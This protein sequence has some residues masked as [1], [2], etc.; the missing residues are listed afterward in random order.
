MAE[1]KNL[2]NETSASTATNR[3]ELFHAQENLRRAFKPVKTSLARAIV[4]TK[5]CKANTSKSETLRLSVEQRV[6]FAI[7]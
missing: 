2:G 4:M 3:T 7:M 5:E 1:W 6:G